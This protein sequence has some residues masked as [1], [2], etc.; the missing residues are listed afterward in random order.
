MENFSASDVE[1]ITGVGRIRVHHWI[2]EGF[3]TPSGEVAKGHGRKNIYTL[4]DLYKIALLKKLI[5]NGLHGWAASSLLGY[6]F[7][8]FRQIYQGMK[9][10]GITDKSL[11]FCVVM[12]FSEEKGIEV[13]TLNNL[14]DIYPKE[15]AECMS[16][17]ISRIFADG[18]DQAVVVNISK[19]F[20]DVDSHI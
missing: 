10:N 16:V 12:K 8:L 3:F 1:R 13:D 6:D 9:D 14:Q 19:L 11:S 20:E 15:H 17:T 18:Y 7:K 2:K 4:E 5:E